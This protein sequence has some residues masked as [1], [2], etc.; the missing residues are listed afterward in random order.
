MTIALGIL[1]TDG[2]VIAADT[3]ESYGY[4]GAVKNDALKIIYFLDATIRNPRGVCAIAGAGDAG[5]VEAITM[6]LGN[7][8]LT[9]HGLQDEKL[10]DA[11]NPVLRRFYDEHIIPF[12]SYPAGERPDATMLLGVQ[13]LGVPRLFV[14]HQSC[15]RP[16]LQAYEAIG[17]GAAFAKM[18]LGRFWQ[19]MDVKAA[20]VL[21]A[22]VVFLTK[23]SV[24]GCGKYT[25]VRTIYGPTFEDTPSG[26]RATFSELVSAL[27]AEEIDDMER[28]FRTKYALMEKRTLWQFVGDCVTPSAAAPKR[29]AARRVPKAPRRDR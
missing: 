25:S 23:E 8:F 5:H 3:Q 6:L 26:S 1:A 4:A 21:A 29:P 2:V 19:P 9:H 11:L 10:L 14:S 18:L 13:R 27:S 22:Y 15:M 20:Q 7:A 17:A 16:V 12:A 24:E 28:L